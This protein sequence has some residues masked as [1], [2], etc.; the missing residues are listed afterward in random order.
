MSQ[1][2]DCLVMEWNE[3]F[4]YCFGGQWMYLYSIMCAK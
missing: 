2:I 4:Y 1:E 3:T